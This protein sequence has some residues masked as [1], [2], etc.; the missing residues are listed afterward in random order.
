VMDYLERTKNDWSP[1]HIGYI[2]A[3]KVQ[4]FVY[5]N[6]SEELKIFLKQQ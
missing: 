5:D 2:N 3:E 1:I 6:F 4:K